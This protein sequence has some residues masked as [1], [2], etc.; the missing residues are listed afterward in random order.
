MNNALFIPQPGFRFYFKEHPD[1]IFEIGSVTY[2]AIRYAA[3]A[4][5][6]HFRYPQMS[7]KAGIHQVK[8]YVSSHQIN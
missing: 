2:N 4:G 5:V 1:Y 7:L 6:N 8:F 3:I